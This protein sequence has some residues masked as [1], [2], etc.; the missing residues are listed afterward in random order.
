MK[1]CT[2]CGKEYPDE[3]TV[4]EL[5]AKP[6]VAIGRANAA[7][8]RTVKMTRLDKLFAD[9]PGI[10]F[11]GADA[12]LLWGVIGVFACKHPS[13]QKNA[14]IYFRRQVGGL[15]LAF[16]IVVLIK[17]VRGMIEKAV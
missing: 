6:L 14:R 9:S 12:R 16:I 17:I 2:Y 5:D 15:V 8:P 11:W 4:C 1:Q 10:S 3:T 13:A 7:P